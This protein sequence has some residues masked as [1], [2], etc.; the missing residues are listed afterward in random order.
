MLC[1][2]ELLNYSVA[3]TLPL[4]AKRRVL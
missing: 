2:Y 1:Y 4:D 3:M